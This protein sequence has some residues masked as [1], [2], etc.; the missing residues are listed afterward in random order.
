MGRILKIKVDEETISAI[1]QGDPHPET[2]RY[3]QYSIS[4]PSKA[5]P[6]FYKRAEALSVYVIDILELPAK[7]A[8]NV[9]V[10]GI[11]FSYSAKIDG[12]GVIFTAMRSLSKT[13]QP[14]VLN[15]PLKYSNH[16]T[17]EMKLPKGCFDAIKDLERELVKYLEGKK[18][19]LELFPLS[20]VA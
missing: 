18:A 6:A 7:E 14:H 5:A 8:K 12:V 9:K 17:K 11:S 19:Q 15:T 16:D 13:P 20:K 4:S 3:D 2:E 10:T 1:W